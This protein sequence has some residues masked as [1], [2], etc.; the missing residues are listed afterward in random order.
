MHMHLTAAPL[1]LSILATADFVGVVNLSEPPL[2]MCFFTALRRMHSNT[3]AER[4]GLSTAKQ[5]DMSGSVVW[6]GTTQP[7]QR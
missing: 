7:L 2:Q 5:T 6:I 1:T 4:S 3:T